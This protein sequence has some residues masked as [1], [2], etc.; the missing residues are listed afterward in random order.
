MLADRL[1]R[2]GDHQYRKFV[3]AKRNSLENMRNWERGI[4]GPGLAV[5][6]RAKLIKLRRTVL[7]WILKK[8]T[9]TFQWWPDKGRKNSEIGESGM[10]GHWEACIFLPKH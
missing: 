2:N 9:G 5:C 6:P 8:K 1:V 7:D 10:P 4:M 3:K